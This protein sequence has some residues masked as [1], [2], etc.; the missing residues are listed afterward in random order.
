MRKQFQM[1][2]QLCLVNAH[3]SVPTM[4]MMI[5]VEILSFLLRTQTATCLSKIL[6]KVSKKQ[7][8]RRKVSGLTSR[9]Q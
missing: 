8:L 3:L 9:E 7:K 6:P 5:I 4:S 1:K 2:F